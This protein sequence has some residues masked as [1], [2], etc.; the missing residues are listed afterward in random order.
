MSSAGLPF[1]RVILHHVTLIGVPMLAA[2]ASADIT[3]PIGVIAQGHS[4]AGPTHSVHLPLELRTIVF[5]QDDR[6]VA[7]IILDII[8]IERENTAR[9]Q[10]QVERRT[11][12]PGD[13]VLI[14]CGHTHSGASTL[15]LISSSADEAYLA[16]LEQAAA[17]SVVEAFGRI[18]PVTIGLGA[19]SA[20][21]NI[22]RRPT[23]DANGEIAPNTAE[24]VDRCIRVLRVDIAMTDALR[25]C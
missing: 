16:T 6:H 2:T 3:P 17:D 25:D 11:D 1:V 9:I 21:F 13:S 19:S 23:S 12:I 15:K 4:P 22:N 7:I 20:H 18:E 10:Q 8:G 24:I 14:A 5:A